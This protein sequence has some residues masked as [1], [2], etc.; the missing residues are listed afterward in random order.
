MLAMICELK[1]A[2]ISLY[3]QESSVAVIR[4]R[5]EDVRSCEWS[6]DAQ[7][8]NYNLYL[9]WRLPLHSTS[10]TLFADFS[11]LSIKL[12][13][14][15]RRLGIYR[16]SEWFK[17]KSSNIKYHKIIILTKALLESNSLVEVHHSTFNLIVNDYNLFNRS[18]Q[19]SDIFVSPLH[20]PSI[21]SQWLCWFVIL[22]SLFAP[23]GCVPA[24]NLYC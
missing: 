5:A 21:Q 11:L 12:Q 2:A 17:I 13:I 23:D 3:F 9:L 16:I 19:T 6:S 10:F 18:L 15:F 7:H 22:S 1:F 14:P 20:F 8:N 24:I 4:V